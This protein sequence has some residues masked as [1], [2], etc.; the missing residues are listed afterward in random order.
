VNTVTENPFPARVEFTGRQ[1]SYTFQ[2]L[3]YTNKLILQITISMV[4]IYAAHSI[5]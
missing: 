4:S 3:Q 5:Y 2:C 1:R